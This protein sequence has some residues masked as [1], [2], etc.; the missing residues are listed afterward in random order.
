MTVAQA[1]QPFQVSQSLLRQGLLWR[2]AG[3][4]A[5]AGSWLTACKYALLAGKPLVPGQPLVTRQP[6]VPRQPLLLHAAWHA[7]SARSWLVVA[8]GKHALLLERPLCPVALR[9]QGLWLRWLCNGPWAIANY[10]FGYVKINVP[11][12]K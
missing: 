6:L 3:H 4:A 5:S 11:Q 12:I 1:L 2:S 10:C 9:L 7:A 8:T